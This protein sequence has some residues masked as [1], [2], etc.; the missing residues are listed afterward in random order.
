[1]LLFAELAIKIA[2]FKSSMLLRLRCKN[3]LSLALR[4]EYG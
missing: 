3:L 4:V 1:M 2:G